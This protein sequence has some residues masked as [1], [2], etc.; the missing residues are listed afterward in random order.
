[1]SGQEELG[2]KREELPD[3]KVRIAFAAPIMLFEEVKRSLTLRPPTAGE[4]WEIG[5]PRSY[6]YNEAG[7]GTPYVDRERLKAWIGK[8][9]VDHDRDLIGMQG[10]AAL[11]LMIEEAVLDFFS[12]ARKRSRSGSA[13]SLQPA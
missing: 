5:D 2:P 10:D 4:I 7:L 13:P 9:M 1:M 3:G 11:G 6:I 8:L 12:K